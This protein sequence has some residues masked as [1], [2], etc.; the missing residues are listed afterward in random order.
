MR[1]RNGARKKGRAGG[2][3]RRARALTLAHTSTYLGEKRR[4]LATTSLGQFE[5]ASLAR[6]QLPDGSDDDALSVN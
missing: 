2:S 6:P 5:G 3:V 4:N 1:R